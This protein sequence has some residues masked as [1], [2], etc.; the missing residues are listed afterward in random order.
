MI[1]LAGPLAAFRHRN[2]R[3][4]FAGQSVSLV[5][6]WVQS[7]AQGW[8]V[9]LLAGGEGEAT[10]WL[11]LT[12][13]VGSLPMFFGAFFG[14]ALA[15]R[16]SKRSLI[17]W[18]QVAQGLLSGLMAALIASGGVRLWHIPLFAL[19]LGITSVFDIP[20]R[21]SFVV[22]M[23]GKDDLPNAIG[24]NS[25]LFNGARVFGPW[26]A[27]ELIRRFGIGSAE[28]AAVGKCFL[29]NALS[30]VPVTFGLL[31]MRGDFSPRARGREPLAAQMRETA[32]YLRGHPGLRALLGILASGS[33]FMTGDWVLLPSL[34]RYTFGADAHD[35][36]QLMALRGVGALAAALLLATLPPE[37]RKGRLI[38]AAALAWPAFSMATALSGSIG[39]ARWLIPGAGFAMICFLVGCNTLLQ[40]STPDHMRGRVMG[41]HAFLMMGLNPPGSLLASAIARATDTRV[42]IA[43]CAAVTL[44]L[45]LFFLIRFPALRRAGRAL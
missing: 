23:V 32:A 5:G 25:S 10:F 18:T 36:G 28:M 17:L 37:T 19:A 7:T 4:F 20:A 29:V 33:L 22:E 31:A 11:G 42:A 35:Y 39:A 30:Y 34:A 16:L 8:L 45:A 12:S 15:D 9:T 13:L 27:A 38:A 1:R 2:Y 3:L 26:I 41:V 14:G 40:T 24:L 6:T 44:T 21:Q 43:A